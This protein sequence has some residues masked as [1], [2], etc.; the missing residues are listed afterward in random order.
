MKWTISQI[1][2]HRNK[3]FLIDE[4]VRMDSVKETDPEIREVSPIKLSGRADISASKVTFQIR[5]QGHMILPCS[6]TLVDVR[7]PIDV[8]TTETFVLNGHDYVAEEDVY[9]VKGDVIDLEPVI[10]EILLLE[11][12]MQV[13]CDDADGQE[14]APQ[15]GKD[16]EVI[17]EQEKQEKLDPRLAGLAKFFEDKDSSD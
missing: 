7:Y 1:Q 17:E 10:R 2:K 9:Q 13:F 15:S 14:G 3:E 8:E 11:V 16:W 12:P 6:R 5:I 4:T